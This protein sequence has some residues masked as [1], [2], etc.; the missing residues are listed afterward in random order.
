[1]NLAADPGRKQ[2]YKRLRDAWIALAHN[3]PNLSSEAIAIDIAAIEQIE[4][5]SCEEKTLH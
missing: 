1:M 5:I 4:F 3:S 2:I